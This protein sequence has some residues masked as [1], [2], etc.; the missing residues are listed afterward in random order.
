MVQIIRVYKLLEIIRYYCYEMIVLGLGKR[1]RDNRTIC[2]VC[3]GPWPPGIIGW[4]SLVSM[5][6][7]QLF[8]CI[9]CLLVAQ[10]TA[11][12]Q[13]HYVLRPKMVIMQ[14]KVG[15]EPGNE[16]R[17][18]WERDYLNSCSL[19]LTGSDAVSS[20]CWLTWKPD[21]EVSLKLVASSSSSSLARGSFK[22]MYMHTCV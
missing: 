12:F 18:G 16:A 7:P 22:T 11:S 1:G 17:L 14:W 10:L 19:L 4:F 6:P 5:T 21:Q 20:G 13:F 9:M 8:G 2:S 3:F 15:E